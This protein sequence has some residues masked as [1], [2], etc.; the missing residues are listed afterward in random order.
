MDEIFVRWGTVKIRNNGKLYMFKDAE[1]NGD[2]CK[3]W[4]WNESKIHH[5][6][7]ITK[8]ALNYTP[9]TDCIIITTGFND[10]LKVSDEMVQYLKNL[11]ILF[12]IVNT[13]DFVEKYE[14]AKSDGK[15]IYAL[16]HSTC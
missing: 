8:A 5:I 12:H 7:G 14:D 10:A 3:E 6:P 2:E 9:E 16:V 1:I 4:D 15:T 11:N 13:G